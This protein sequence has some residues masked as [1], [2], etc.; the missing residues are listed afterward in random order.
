MPL[1]YEQVCDHIIQEIASGRLRPGDRLP[2]EQEY[3]TSFG[4]SRITI[5]RAMSRLQRDG[6]IERF[7]GKGTF[8]TERAGQV[9]TH[10]APAPAISSPAPE[11][12]QRRIGFIIPEISDLLGVMMFNG[13]DER[14][15]ECNLDLS[16]RRSHGNLDIE[17]RTITSWIASGLD[18]I[19]IFPSHGEF[20][21]QTLLR[22][23]LSGFPV[24]LVD[25]T[26][27]GIPVPSVMTDHYKAA[28]AITGWLLEQGHASL[29]FASP[30]VRGTSSLE[31]RYR[32]F[33]DAVQ[34]ANSKSPRRFSTLTLDSVVPGNST[35]ENLERD[36]DRIRAF[37]AEHPD[38]SAI[39]ASEF[40]VALLIEGVIA[41]DPALRDRNV[42]IAC[43]D[44]LV[45]S[46]STRSFAH[47]KQD[48]HEI[49]R[50]A[51]DLL[52]RQFDGETPT[53]RHYVDFALVAGDPARA[54]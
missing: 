47:I 49:G 12:H 25:R 35:A 13:I 51:V 4:V 39:L 31:E 16:I 17:A 43:F 44:S 7:R 30:S 41:Q 36:R 32:G 9:A 38:L 5:R 19:I 24:V 15:Q 28:Q 46:M 50:Q 18:G 42:E 11:A 29:G 23:V 2:T 34:A 54:K 6:L 3:A 27:G 48:E 21:N 33:L 52:L 53:G 40:G 37:L 10:L 1:L 14:C 8:V 20:Y 45:E 22:A 26:L